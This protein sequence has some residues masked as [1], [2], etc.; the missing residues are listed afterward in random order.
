MKPHPPATSPIARRQFLQ[1]GG[2][3]GAGLACLAG[4]R[5]I[6]AGVAEMN[7]LDY[8]RSFLIGRAPENRVRFWI[9]SRTRI[10]DERDK[11]HEDFYQCASCK[12]EDTFAEKDLFKPDNYDFLPVFG[13]E[14]GVIFRRRAWL[15]PSYRSVLKAAE[16]WGGQDYKLRP[17]GRARL[18]ASTEEVRRASHAGEPVVAQT[19]IADET[20]GLRAI[21]EF[22]VKTLNIHDERN[23]HQV[24][25]GPVAFP[26]L[27]RRH[28][29]F[30]ESL[31]LAFVAFNA[32][33]FADFII[34][35][36][37]PLKDHDPAQIHHYSR[38]LSL[39][40]KNRLYA[41]GE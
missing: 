31:S 9:E 13:T 3:A 4:A 11:R 10:I 29:G 15:N 35:D 36:A 19:E 8:G 6:A 28:P 30:A 27:G 12:A 17:A 21:I 5:A 2:L 39:P 26:D 25:T 16:M 22:P 1:R 14:G 34:E 38:I 33:H 40:A 23:L 32:P 18:L 20:T 37:T 7:I 41:L 24:D